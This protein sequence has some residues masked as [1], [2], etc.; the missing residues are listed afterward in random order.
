MT[1]HFYSSTQN[2]SPEP[3]CLDY[4]F[5]LAL[6]HEKEMPNAPVLD[7]VIH[8]Q[9]SVS[10][11]NI[12]HHRWTIAHPKTKTPLSCSLKCTSTS[13]PTMCCNASLH[14]IQQ[15]CIEQKKKKRK[16]LINMSFTFN[17]KGFK[18]RTAVIFKV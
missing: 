7:F 13:I 5:M 9:R 2:L 17:R 16:I 3:L 15:A 10:E 8:W 12:R 14:L 6:W 1:S 11:K 18:K 4:K